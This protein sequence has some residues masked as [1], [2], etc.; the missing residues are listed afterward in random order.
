MLKGII[1]EMMGLAQTIHRFCEHL[2][3]EFK[4][5]Y[6][7]LII[8]DIEGELGAYGLILS[9]GGLNRP[10]ATIGVY[11]N[12]KFAEK[13]YGAYDLDYLSVLEAYPCEWGVMSIRVHARQGPK[14]NYRSLPTS[15]FYE[16]QFKEVK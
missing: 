10:I 14:G 13:Y 4:S 8:L 9:P 5:G 2:M 6:E 12:R 7:K 3:N 11:K 15:E 16:S 1:E